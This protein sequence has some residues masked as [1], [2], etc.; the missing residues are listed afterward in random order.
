LNDGTAI[1]FFTLVLGLLAGNGMSASTLTIDFVTV[2]GAGAIV[3][4]IVGLA[5]SQIIKRI[6]DPMIEITLT[7]M[8]A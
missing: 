7:T 1:V 3:G 2:V 8:A 4:A 5:V 6:D